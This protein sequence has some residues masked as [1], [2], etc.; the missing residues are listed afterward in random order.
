MGPSAGLHACGKSLHQRDSIPGQSSPQRVA[1]P[2]YSGP[3][4]WNLNA[5]S[6]TI[7]VLSHMDQRQRQ[8]LTPYLVKIH[9]TQ[10]NTTGSRPELPAS[11]PYTHTLLCKNPRNETERQLTSVRRQNYSNKSI[12]RQHIGISLPNLDPYTDI[13]LS[14]LEICYKFRNWSFTLSNTPCCM[15]RRSFRLLNTIKQCKNFDCSNWQPTSQLLCNQA[16]QHWKCA[17]RTSAHVPSKH[18]LCTMT[19]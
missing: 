16:Y 6:W 17:I 18:V 8:T 9:A 13:P 7:H 11:S 3:L 10:H 5:R 15:E 2:S 19:F 14:K 4:L 12:S 1:I